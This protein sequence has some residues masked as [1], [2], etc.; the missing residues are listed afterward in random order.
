MSSQWIINGLLIDY[1]WI[2]NRLLIDYW[3]EKISANK[4]W[5]SLYISINISVDYKII[6]IYNKLGT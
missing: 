5:K 3:Y 4:F 1:Q 6:V 2:V